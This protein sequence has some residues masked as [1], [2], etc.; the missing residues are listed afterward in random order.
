VSDTP[1]FDLID[2]AQTLARK[3]RFILMVGLIAAIVAAGSYLLST[4]K[5]KASS[6]F[7]VVNPL[8]IDRNNIFRNDKTAFTDYYGRED[9]VDKFLAVAKADGTR[10]TIIQ[11]AQ[12]WARFAVDTNKEKKWRKQVEMRFDRSFEVKRTEYQAVEI[13]YIDADPKLAADLCNKSVDIINKVYSG[14]YNALRTANRNSIAGRLRETDSTIAVLTDSL[15][16]MRDRYGIYDIIS[17]TRMGVSN[18]THRGGEG[19]GRAIEEIQ[20]IEATKDQLVMDHMRFISLINEFSTGMHP[21][22]QPQLQIISPAIVPTKPKGLGL[23]LTALVG[24]AVASLF[25]ALWVLMATYFRKLT[26]V[27]R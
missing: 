10:D 6:S 9:D 2:I 25:A 5:Y 23:I 1:R 22:D 4:K 20:N 3:A 24:A 14:N 11:A 27:Q 12:L 17:P 21:G 18:L 19:Y 8:Y 13:T 26:S 7:L 16:S 15:S